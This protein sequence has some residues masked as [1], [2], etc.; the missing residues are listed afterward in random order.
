MKLLSVI[1]PFY[2]EEKVLEVVY[3][4][5]ALRNDYP[6]NM[7]IIAVDDGSNKEYIETGANTLKNIPIVKFLQHPKNL[8]K[9]AAIK[10]GLKHCTGDIII[11]QDGD[12]EYSICDIPLVIQPIL[13]KETLVCYG[14]RHLSKSQRKTHIEWFKKHLRQTLLPMI[15]GRLITLTCN[16]LF[17]TKLTDILTCYKAFDRSFIESFNFHN[18]GFNMEA[19][20]T[21]KVLKRTSIIEIPIHY[22]PRTKKE[23]KKITILDGL[24]LLFTIIIYRFKKPQ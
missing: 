3:Q 2:N 10:T 14:S 11:I 21:A 4:L 23:G 13:N 15:G 8:G 5:M 9:G 1:L 22:F 18:N 6:L 16:V 19:E 24:K 17:G 7:E 12:L 20:I